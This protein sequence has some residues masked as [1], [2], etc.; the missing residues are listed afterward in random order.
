[1]LVKSDFSKASCAHSIHR[2]KHTAK[3]KAGK[4][5]K[6]VKYGME[7]CFTNIFRKVK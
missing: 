4:C 7:I 1:M 6:K 2:T 3:G 5:K